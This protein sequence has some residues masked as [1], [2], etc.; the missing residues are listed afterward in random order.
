MSGTFEPPL[1]PPPELRFRR[2]I[3]LGVAMRDLWQARELVR[4][5]VERD[6]RAQ[7][8]QTI[9]GFAWAVIP[10]VTFMVLFSL[11]FRRVADV[12]TEGVPYSLFTYVGLLPWTFFSGSVSRGG[13][14]LLANTALLNRMY[15]PRE[16][17]PIAGMISA[18]IDTLVALPVLGILFLLTGF[19]PKPTVVFVPLLFV[20]Q[21]L[22][23]LGVTLA[24]SSIVVYF[25]DLRHALPLIL[26]FGIFA[27]PVA[28]SVDVIPK[29]LRA[30][31]AVLNPLAPV[32]DGY[33][34]V[35][36]LGRAPAWDTLLPGAA[37]A[38][39]VMLAAYL[40]FKHLETGLADV[41]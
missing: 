19:A 5:L 25:R 41:A 27:T 8:K 31:Y 26:Q 24:A 33:R 15:C 29:S 12:N 3:R 32:I 30:L 22:F 6:F 36:L 28:Y 21:L 39:G 37:A 2:H 18:G 14:S 23:T 9:L 34:Q 11:F 38:G 40:L 7:Y 17:F 1:A 16:I 35:V 10:P 20:I 4:T 13:L